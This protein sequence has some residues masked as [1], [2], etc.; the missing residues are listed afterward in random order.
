MVG[1]ERLHVHGP[2]P[3][4]AHLEWPFLTDGHRHLAQA[5][6]AWLAT[7]ELDVNTDWAAAVRAA[8]WPGLAT[9]L[10]GCA[11]LAEALAAHHANA[12]PAAQALFAPAA[13]LGMAR[14]IA[15]QWHLALT[16]AQCDA[17][18]TLACVGRLEALLE[19]AALGVYRTAWQQDRH[20]NDP[21]IDAVAQELTSL[22]LDALLHGL[23]D[24]LGTVPTP[25]AEAGQT[26]LREAMKDDG[27]A[28][29]AKALAVAQ[30]VG[31]WRL[32][33]P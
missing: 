22:M 12:E 13:T 7:T 25:G 19:A 4:S 9:D 23:L 26:A 30:R 5:V 21:A 20:A 18:A 27:L 33:H 16:P 11:V 6:H 14:R 15:R 1:F 24:A 31:R 28:S 29:P 32:R 8:G 10:R 3:A 2:L 17:S